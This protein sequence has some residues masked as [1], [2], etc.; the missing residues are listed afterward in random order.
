MVAQEIDSFVSRVI[1]SN[2]K[3]QILAKKITK[4]DLPYKKGET[5]KIILS[6]VKRNNYD[7]D[8]VDT[9]VSY[10]PDKKF[11]D[12]YYENKY[13]KNKKETVKDGKLDCAACATFAADDSPVKPEL[14][15][16]LIWGSVAVLGL[17][18]VLASLS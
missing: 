4:K 16:N 17:T 15:K 9:I 12:V 10:H 3:T 8:V 18:F 5:E 7:N 11:F 13:S 14:N 6:Y 1:N 2:P